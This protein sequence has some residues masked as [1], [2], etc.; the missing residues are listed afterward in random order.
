MAK[1]HITEVWRLTV[2]SFN[3]IQLTPKQQAL[4]G[5]AKSKLYVNCYIE[6]IKRMKDHDVKFP[7][8]PS[9]QNELGINITEFARW[10]AFR[11]RGPLYK[12]KTINS[13][14]A[15]DIE[16]IGI[17]ISSQKS[18][19]KSKA[20]VL[21]AKQGN[22]INEQSKYIIELSSKVDLLQATLDEKNTKIKELEAKLAAS[23]NAYSEMM[24]SHSEQIKDSILSG[25][26]TFEC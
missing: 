17:E 24:R 9:G 1:T 16:N 13:R 12:N 19:T 15:K 14:L 5:T 7:P 8:D 21:I 26:R 18:S 2:K 4:K 11:D 3:Y 23:N 22:N 10:C 20:D 25:G 6:M